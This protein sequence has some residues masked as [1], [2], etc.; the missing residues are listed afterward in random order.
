M[1]ATAF[2]LH[3]LKTRVTL[4]TLAIFLLSVL[5]L[6]IYGKGIVRKSVLGLMSSQQFL[7]AS[8]IATGVNK[9]LNDRLGAIESIAES[10]STTNLDDTR[11]LQTVLE[12]SPILLDT[13]NTGSVIAGLDGVVKASA[14]LSAAQVGVGFL[15]RDIIA[16]TIKNG[17]AT[18][19]QPANSGLTPIF[20]IAAPI[21]DSQG[22]LVGVLAGLADLRKP[23]FIEKFMDSSYGKSGGYLFFSAERKLAIAAHDKAGI[24]ETVLGLENTPLF[25]RFAEG[26][27]GSGVAVNSSGEEV[28]AS[29][30]GFPLTGWFVVVTLTTDEA[31]APFHAARKQM[32]LATILL[33]ALA[34]AA[35]WLM[36]RRELSPM[37]AAAQ[38]LSRQSKSDQPPQA[39]TITRQDEIGELIGGFNRLLTT[40]NQREESLRAAEAELRIAA[41]AFESQEGMIIT[42]ADGKIL[43]V[44][45]SFTEITGY[46]AD[47]AIGQTPSMLKSGRHDA[48]FY[49]GMWEKIH[50]TGNWQGEIWDKRKNGEIYPKWLSIT[51]VKPE[52]GVV[53]HYVGSQV[54]I[55]ERRATEDAI[56]HLAFFD[57]LTKLPNRRLLNDRLGQSMAASKR[58]GHYN[59]LMFL[60]LDNFKP[61]NDE[62]GHAVGDLLLIE[63]ANR[64]R[65]CVREADTVA[66][67]GGDEFVVILSE[68][69]A[70][71]VESASQARIVAEKI[72]S[73]L[74]APYL[75]SVHNDEKV[76]ATVEHHCT[77]SIGVVMFISH[78]AS[79]DDVLKWADAAM[80]RA[81]DAGRNSIHFF[82][83]TG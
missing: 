10:L 31:L 24:T 11:A 80:Y 74:S 12:Q 35:I 42:D 69:N 58:S 79:Q 32:L 40:L 5:A 28:L 56:R 77:A 75:L 26:Y 83:H 68:L 21:H 39:L 2:R 41:V 47:E 53:T 7:T 78:E 33:A 65:N 9:E 38:T 20:G 6:A 51:A 66:R 14:P 8:A 76:D 54:D 45:K 29:A 16:A 19:G 13:F 49:A 57:S 23:N 44:N 37:V 67:F 50:R 64:L 43:R 71:E 4:F 73:W 46:A 59:A 36:L 3:S 61:L 72:R 34:G 27:E 70:D 81:K 55:T 18:I 30:K 62:Y 15:Q 60:D 63:A 25:R 22:K 17:K 1:S 82:A 52:N 48:S